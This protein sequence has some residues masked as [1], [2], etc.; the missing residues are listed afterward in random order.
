MGAAS[1]GAGI[2][3]QV[4]CLLVLISGCRRSRSILQ[5]YLSV[6]FL[7]WGHRCRAKK[8][9]GTHWEDWNWSKAS[10]LVVINQG[11]CQR[12]LICE[13]GTK[14]VEYLQFLAE[15]P[16]LGQ[17]FIKSVF[18]LSMFARRSMRAVITGCRVKD[19]L[20]KSQEISVVFLTLL[21]SSCVTLGK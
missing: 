14:C 15:E 7:V 16:A 20:P 9:S 21:L 13:K 2:S 12:N 1:E 6:P 8:E 4:D 11:V 5:S 17:Y 18:K 10:I 19:L 3:Q